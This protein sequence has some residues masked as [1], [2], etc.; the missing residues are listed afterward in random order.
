MSQPTPRSV[1]RTLSRLTD[2]ET[3]KLVRYGFGPMLGLTHLASEPE[4]AVLVESVLALHTQTGS[5][6]PRPEDEANAAEVKR[7]QRQFAKRVEE[8]GLPGRPPLTPGRVLLAWALIWA[9]ALVAVPLAM[10]GGIMTAGWALVLFGVATFFLTVLTCGFVAGRGHFQ[11]WL[12][13]LPI[14][15]VLVGAGGAATPLYLKSRGT[16]VQ[17]EFGQAYKTGKGRYVKEHC[18]I[19]WGPPG[20]RQATDVTGCPDR[21]FRMHFPGR[22]EHIPVR[23]VRSPNWVPSRVGTKADLSLT[24]QAAVVGT[25]LVLLAGLT[26]WGVA[27]AARRRPATG[28]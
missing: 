19:A 8:E 24:W 11:A 14:L 2:R 15:L 1:R 4:G 18:L 13:L 7:R 17:G 10:F 3:A 21:F 20:N 22:D 12:A 16:E 28:Q 27:T 25:G 6:P 9:I 23:F 26:A 5:R